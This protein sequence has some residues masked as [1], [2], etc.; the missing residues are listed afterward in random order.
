[1][2]E[3]FEEI[4]IV[5]TDGNILYS[6]SKHE[7]HQKGLLHKTVIAGVF[8]SKGEVILVEQSSDRQDAGQYVSP[9]GGHQKKGET[10]EEALKREVLEEIG[11]VDFEYK[12]KGRL[13][14]NRQVLG[15]LENHFFVVFEIYTDQDLV[16]GDEADSYRK[17]NQSE[18]KR[19]LKENPK[20]FGDAY[21][22]I[23]QKFYPELL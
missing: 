18:L 21:F 9:V 3:D 6:I 22:P 11:L 20:Q 12:L 14:F 1:M 4:D 23:V 10:E 2:N 7:A 17:F 16:L 15:R 13:V 5:D 8:S 19:L